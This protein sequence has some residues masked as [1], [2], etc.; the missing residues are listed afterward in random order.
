MRLSC[1]KALLPVVALATACHETTAPP[2]PGLYLLETFNNR[3]L[4]TVL[5]AGT[6]DTITLVGATLA[7][8]G[9]ASAVVVAHSREVHPDLPPRDVIDTTRYLY[10][11]LGDSI[12]FDNSPDCPLDALCAPPPYGKV[13]SSTMTLFEGVAPNSRYTYFYRAVALD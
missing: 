3:P 8:D 5:V 1:L 6:R 12:A 11:I 9:T 13:T 2:A 4:P 10:H 7:L